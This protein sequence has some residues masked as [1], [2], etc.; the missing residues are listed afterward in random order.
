MQLTGGGAGYQLT[1]RRC[2]GSRSGLRGCSA[3]ACYVAATSCA[4]ACCVAA[5]SGTRARAEIG[6]RAAL[7][8]GTQIR[9]A[10]A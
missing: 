2:S 4:R 8:D 7:S 9:G 1:G 5:T 3:R 6:D 10:T